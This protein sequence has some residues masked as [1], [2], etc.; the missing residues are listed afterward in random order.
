M[1]YGAT[2]FSRPMIT[3]YDVER[4]NLRDEDPLL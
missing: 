2:Y 4:N 3:A 1:S